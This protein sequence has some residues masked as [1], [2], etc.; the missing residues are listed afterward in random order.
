M[1][2]DQIERKLKEAEAHNAQVRTRKEMYQERLKKEFQ[3]DSVEELQAIADHIQEQLATLEP[4][5]RQA[6][7]DIETKMKQ[8][9]II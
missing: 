9:G 5:Y 8:V 7:C 4:R 2:L 1:T 3:V 6:M